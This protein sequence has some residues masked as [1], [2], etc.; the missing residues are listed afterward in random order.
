[1]ASHQ[2]SSTGVVQSQ[3]QGITVKEPL[4]ALMH[5]RTK[6]KQSKKTPTNPPPFQQMVTNTVFLKHLDSMKIMAKNLYFCHVSCHRIKDFIILLNK[7]FAKEIALYRTEYRAMQFLIPSKSPK[8]V[9]LRT[10]SCHN[11]LGSVPSLYPTDY[12]PY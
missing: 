10:R 4:W 12:S 7:M 8:K 6:A 5:R 2:S 11:H 9:E 3:H 1:M